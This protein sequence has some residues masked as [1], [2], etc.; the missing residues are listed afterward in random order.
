MTDLPAAIAALRSDVE[1]YDMVPRYDSSG[2][3]WALYAAPQPSPQAEPVGDWVMVPREPTREMQFKGQHFM[4]DEAGDVWA[5]MLAAAPPR[6][7]ASA[8]DERALWGV[9]ANAG[10][11]SVKRKVRW[12]HVSDATGLGSNK[13][14]ELCRRF[15][16]DPDEL[17]GGS[18]SL[19]VGK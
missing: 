12:A 10:R 14:A 11:L 16:R 3:D 15:E 19:G 4:G 5:A 13:S 17:V 2:V 9:V 8:E 6:P 7:Q 18:A 1:Q